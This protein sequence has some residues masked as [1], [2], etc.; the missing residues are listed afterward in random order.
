[1]ITRNWGVLERVDVRQIW[2]HE[3]QNFTVW[4][5]ENLQE[6]ER[7]SKL[8]LELIRR[9]DSSG[10]G[11]VDILAREVKSG[12]L[13]VIE[14]QLQE[15]D[16]GHFERLMGYIASR[17]TDSSEPG[18]LVWVTT[19]FAPW[20]RNILEW[21]NKAGVNAFGLEVR[22]YRIREIYGY[23]FVKVVGPD[24]ESNSA[25]IGPAR[26]S[27]IFGRFYRPLTDQLRGEG[28]WAMG[29]RQGGFTGRYR[30][31]RSGFESLGAAY[32][33]CLGRNEERC[34][35]ALFI[36]GDHRQAI[37]EGLVQHQEELG[38]EI[39]GNSLRW[40]NSES[41]WGS[42]IWVETDGLSN[43]DDN[44][45]EEK[46]TWMFDNLVALRNAVQPRL[47]QVVDSLN[48]TIR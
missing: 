20:Y 5:S 15:A 22:A 33:L 44:S 40:E 19:G 25:D 14:N 21:L 23:E 37:Y 41:T 28:I 2:P 12:R 9:E 43:E 18:I 6:L 1:M 39:T 32:F 36:A 8:Q 27:S 10:L 48:L 13:V 45:L 38:G 34:S 31:F 42:W 17:D 30:S 47:R 3:E 11:R 4:L 46:R 7:A 26:G 24:D 35:A 16:S 29:G